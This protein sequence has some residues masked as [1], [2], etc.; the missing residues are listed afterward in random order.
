[1]DTLSII[2]WPR[3]SNS[4]LTSPATSSN[5]S[6]GLIKISP[7][8]SAVDGAIGPPMASAAESHGVIASPGNSDVASRC[9]VKNC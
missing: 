9:E 5:S 3:V 2:T 1:M 4:S 7:T 8:T 6:L